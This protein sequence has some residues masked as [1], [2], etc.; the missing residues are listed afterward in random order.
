MLSAETARQS[1]GRSQN[2]QANSA[3]C[4]LQFALS[5]LA[6][7]LTEVLDLFHHS[8]WIGE[9]GLLAERGVSVTR[10]PVVVDLQLRVVETVGSNVSSE[11]R[12]NQV[13]GDC[14]N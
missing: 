3:I 2:Q 7:A 10:L 12:E 14:T 9:L 8:S 5:S 6:F 4:N 11:L 1:H 13:L